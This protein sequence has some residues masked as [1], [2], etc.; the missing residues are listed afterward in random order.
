MCPIMVLCLNMAL[1]DINRTSSD[2]ISR[3]PDSES[4]IQSLPS[5]GPAKASARR[6]YRKPAFCYERVFETQVMKCFN[7]GPSHHCSS[8]RHT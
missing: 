4:D 3:D 7:H 5:A 2:Q 1:S 8:P 6:P